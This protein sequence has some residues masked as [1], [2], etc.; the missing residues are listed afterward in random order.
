MIL[1]FVLVIRNLLEKFI[2]VLIVFLIIAIFILFVRYYKF[3]FFFSNIILQTFINSIIILKF[4][5][6]VCD[7]YLTSGIELSKK[8]KD[9][10]L[11]SNFNQNLKKQNTDFQEIIQKICWGCSQKSP[12]NFQC[13]NCMNSF[14]M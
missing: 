6:K 9:N 14:C 1:Y 10:D 2:F 11:G 4:Y 13:Q 5:K 3:Y 8:V 12:Q 7:C